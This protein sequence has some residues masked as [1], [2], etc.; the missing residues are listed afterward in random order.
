[1]AQRVYGTNENWGHRNNRRTVGEPQNKVNPRIFDQPLQQYN[2]MRTTT[3]QRAIGEQPRLNSYGGHTR[4]LFSEP[5]LFS[6]PIKKRYWSNLKGRF[7]TLNQKTATKLNKRG[8]KLVLMTPLLE[9]MLSKTKTIPQKENLIRYWDL[10]REKYVNITKRSV[11]IINRRSSTPRFQ[12]YK[13]TGRDERGGKE[14]K[15]VTPENVNQTDVNNAITDLK[16]EQFNLKSWIAEVN[17]RLSRQVVEL[18]QSTT[19]RSNEINALNQ[20]AAEASE[21]ANEMNERL[22]GQMVEVGAAVSDVS[23][24]LQVVKAEKLVE[25]VK[26]KTGGILGGISAYFGDPRTILLGGVALIII[27]IL[28]MKFRK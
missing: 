6:A 25:E 23:K 26:Q 5:R 14:P 27:I 15:D 11:D 28:Y 9:S 8:W 10:A 12:K 17:S 19:D 7:Y 2:T 21:Y 24:A 22:S 16:T 13:P 3:N 20:R 18:G 1:M 4:N